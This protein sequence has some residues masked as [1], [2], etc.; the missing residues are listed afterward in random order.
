MSKLSNNYNITCIV[1]PPGSG[2][3]ATAQYL[4]LDCL[5]QNKK[6]WSNMPFYGAYKLDLND[7]GEVNFTEIDEEGVFII[8]EAGI[9]FNS[10]QWEKLSQNIIEF[11]KYHR[12][13]RLDIYFFSQG[14]DIDKSIRTLSQQ[15][16]KVVKL[17]FPIF[18]P[19]SALIPVSVS[20]NIVNGQ[21]KL[22]YKADASIFSWRF[23]PIYKTFG[24][25]DSFSRPSLPDKE[26]EKWDIKVKEKQKNQ[27]LVKIKNKIIFL[28]DPIKNHIKKFHL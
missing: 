23:I 11:L 24:Y 28:Y 8:D 3:S 26:F 18:H 17:K 21:W 1:G 16:Y 4:I 2:K 14:D 9:S 19:Y 12:H 5:K 25:Y 7:L 27:I 15:W 13:F 20:L 10:R 22:E 6:V